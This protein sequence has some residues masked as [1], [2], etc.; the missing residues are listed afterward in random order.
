MVRTGHTLVDVLV[1]GFHHFQESVY[2][3][4]S[5]ATFQSRSKFDGFHYCI[6]EPKTLHRSQRRSNLI[7]LP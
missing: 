1:S 3:T 4:L 5:I 7:V 2:L 6:L